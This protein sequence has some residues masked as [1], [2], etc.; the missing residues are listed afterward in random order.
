MPRPL[1]YNSLFTDHPTTGHSATSVIENVVEKSRPVQTDSTH[2]VKMRRLT[3]ESRT[4][5]KPKY[6]KTKKMLGN[7]VM[8]QNGL[9][10]ASRDADDRNKYE[11]QDGVIRTGRRLSSLTYLLT[12]WSR[13]LLEKLTGSAASQEI[14]RIFGTHKCPPPVPIL[15]QLHPVLTTPSHFLKI[16]LNIILPLNVNGHM[17][18]SNG[19]DSGTS[20]CSYSSV[21]AETQQDWTSSLTHGRS[22]GL[23]AIVKIS[24]DV[25]ENG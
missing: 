24:D 6:W 20:L 8:R 14:P 4:G 21:L 1:L 18:H 13:V 19:R 16:H 7:F 2:V 25:R 11:G 22:V 10:V 23:H 5:Q 9:S 15:S 3:T 17:T 12:P